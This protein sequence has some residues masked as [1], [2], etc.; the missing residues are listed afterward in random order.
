MNM[1]YNIIRSKRETICI[2]ISPQ[3]EVII[4]APYQISSEQIDHFVKSK[5][6]WIREHLEMQAQRI[7]LNYTE[8]ITGNRYLFKGKAYTLSKHCSSQTCDKVVLHKDT[9]LIEVFRNSN[10]PLSLNDIMR[11]WYRQNAIKQLTSSASSIIE[12][13]RGM[14]PSPSKIAIKTMTSRWGSCS[15]K[16]FITLND[17]LIKLDDRLIRYVILHELCHLKYLNHSQNFYDM[18][19]NFVPDYMELRADLR[20]YSLQ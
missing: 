17:Q 10:S 18:F 3:Q 1:K 11:F 7:S 2:V 20:K 15:S 6:E 13:Y 4:K 9:A 16:G 5:S 14:L 8:Y 19:K 12:E